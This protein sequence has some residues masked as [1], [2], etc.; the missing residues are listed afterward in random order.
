MI[1]LAR[2]SAYLLI[3]LGGVTTA[4]LGIWSFVLDFG[5]V[6]QRLGFWGAVIGLLFFPITIFAAPLYAGFALHWWTPALVGVAGTVVSSP[7]LYL[8][9]Y[10]LGRANSPDG[11]ERARG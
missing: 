1:R 11:A 8:G 7:L 9:M 6:V 3:G 10:L 4:I 2:W 5:I